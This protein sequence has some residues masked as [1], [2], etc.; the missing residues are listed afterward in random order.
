VKVKVG[1][2]EIMANDKFG[3]I[4]LPDNFNLDLTKTINLASSVQAQIDE[5]NRRTKQFA[6]EAYSNRQRELNAIEQTAMNTAETN[7][8][9]QKVV[10]NQNAYIDI[11]KEQL[12]TQK[13][14]MELNEEQLGILN[15]IFASSEDGVIVEKEIM[16]LI[17]DQIDSSH[18]LW[19]YVKDKGGDIAVVGATAGAPVVYASIKMFLASKGI[20]LP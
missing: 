4:K 3:G 9:L 10:D 17:Q 11:L 7:V 14:Q 15:N 6:E 18:P 8:Q 19:D 20:M 16:K 1:K 2:G 12:A 5:S 13:K